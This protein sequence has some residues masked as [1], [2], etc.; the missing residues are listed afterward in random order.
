MP[1]VSVII[2]IYNVERYIAECAK[3]LFE[4]TLDDIEYVFVNDCS[5]DKSIEVLNGVLL[6][7]PSRNQQVKIIN[8]EKNL[9]AAIARKN[10]ILAA[11]GEYVIHCDSDDWVDSEMYQIL[12]EKAQE[13]DLDIVICQ[14]LEKKKGSSTLITHELGT[15]PKS[16]IISTPLFCSL[17][18]KLVRRSII[19]WNKILYPKHHMMEDAVLCVQMFYFAR[20]IGYVS[21]PLYYYRI[22]DNSICHVSTEEGDLKR[23]RDAY[24]NSQIVVSF[25]K[26]EGVCEKYKQ[27]LIQFKSCVRGFL[28]PQMKKSNKYYKQWCGTYPEL[29]RQFLLA[30]GFSRSLKLV[31]ILTLLK[32]YPLF[33]R[34][35]KRG[36]MLS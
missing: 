36:G 31:Y 5:P 30:K 20:K 4:Q 6:Q 21:K 29:N 19:N 18:N 14:Y 24:E 34:L 23:W 35:R 15:S 12:Y 10:G 2:P 32:V 16:K 28:M 22:N 7:Y 25:L 8:H 1:K 33:S 13:E 26:K 17:W 9:G 11:T 27:E 3:S